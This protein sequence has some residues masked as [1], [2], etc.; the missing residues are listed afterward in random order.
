M[1]LIFNTS[2]R[3]L[4]LMISI[5]SLSK[6]SHV[7]FCFSD[8][9]TIYPS[10]YSC[11][12]IMTRKKY[13]G[14]GVTPIELNIDKKEEAIIRSWAESQL[15]VPYDYSAFVIP[16]VD[17][18]IPRKKDSW[19]DLGYWQ[20]SEFCAYGLDLIGWDL[21]SNDFRMIRPV[22]LYRKI[23]EMRDNNDKRIVP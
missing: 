22:D 17:K 9:L 5:F 8:G 7:E 6:I 15:G 19:K 2:V 4:P 18:V 23:I 3:P 10:P 13:S 16:V 12:V 14:S 21:F 11:K 20:C 1:K